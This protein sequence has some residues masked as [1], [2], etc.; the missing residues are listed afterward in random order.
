[1]RIALVHMRHA[2][3]G[4]TERY[5]NHIAAHLA[6]LGHEVTIICRSHTVAPHAA[7]RFQRLHNA[8]LGR[9]HRMWA[10]AK[11]VEQ[12]VVRT[13]YDVVFGLGKT[14]THDVLRMG[15]G[16]YQSW[17]DLVH[18]ASPRLRGR[19]IEP[20]WLKIQLALHLEARALRHGPLQR[21]ITNSIMV[22]WDVMQRYGIPADTITVIHNGVDLNR[23]RPCHRTGA[24]KVLRHACGFHADHT[25]VLFLGTGYHR[26]GLDRLLKVFP[27]LLRE[28]PE[29][30][31]LVIGR[32][33][34]LRR[35]QAWAKRLGLKGWVYFL[36]ARQDPEMGYGASDLYVLPTRYDAFANTTLEALAS[37]MPVITT[38]TNGGC[39]VMQHGV[40][41]A[42]LPGKDD[43]AALLQELLRWTDRVRLVQGARAAR[44]QAEYYGRERELEASMAVLMQAAAAKS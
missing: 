29:V 13:H 40:H 34:H 42:V 19:W 33:A 8:A 14:W 41:G 15:G 6:E 32:D 12:H 28:R 21:I 5:L 17:I 39:E 30:R 11:A 10:F 2:A 22:K 4:G 25:V 23:F 1:M 3:T 31:L 44:A 27:A 24:G 16:C 18:N 38:D 36:G 7:V 26:K 20:Q 35:W 37:G 9:T 43:D